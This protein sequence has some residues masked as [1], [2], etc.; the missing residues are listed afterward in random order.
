MDLTD[1]E[2]TD[3]VSKFHDGLLV[4]LGNPVHDVYFFKLPSAVEQE[5][6]Q[7]YHSFLKNLTEEQRHI[8]LGICTYVLGFCTQYGSVSEHKDPSGS[9]HREAF[10]RLSCHYSIIGASLGRA[11]APKWRT[12]TLYGE[13]GA[14]S[15]MLRIVVSGTTEVYKS[16]SNFDVKQDLQKL[17]IELERW[18]ERDIFDLG[19]YT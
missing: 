18:V 11:V 7:R 8:D 3:L 16:F 1:E 4:S 6:W 9:V 14:L 10:K 15:I 13:H 12:E 5:S 19:N 17:G 2:V